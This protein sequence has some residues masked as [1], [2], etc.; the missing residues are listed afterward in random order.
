MLPAAG[1]LFDQTIMAMIST[2]GTSAKWRSDT[3]RGSTLRNEV[4]GAPEKNASVLLRNTHLMPLSRVAKIR[5]FPK[6]NFKTVPKL[7][8]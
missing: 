2:S 7:T 3:S 4:A 6:V 1:A 8:A 5:E